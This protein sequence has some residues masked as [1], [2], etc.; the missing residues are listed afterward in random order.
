MSESAHSHYDRVLQAWRDEAGFESWAAFG[1]ATGLTRYRVSALRRAQ[2]ERLPASALFVACKALK[3]SVQ[4]YADLLDTDGANH[5]REVA[6]TLANRNSI[7]NEEQ[8]QRQ[9]LNRLEPLLRQ[10]PTAK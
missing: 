7:L 10:Y 4:D 1:R 8:W 2:L 6:P 9:I 5:T 3:R